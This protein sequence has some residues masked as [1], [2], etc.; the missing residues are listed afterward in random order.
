M[1]KFAVLA[2]GAVIVANASAQLWDNG[3]ISTG[4][5]H[6]TGVNAPGGG[7]W[8]E[9][10]PT[11][12]TLGFGLNNASNIRV[13]DDF[14]VGGGGWHV[15]S[16]QFY[17]YLTGAVNPTATAAT[18]AIWNGRPGDAGSSIILGDQATNVMS[19]VVMSNI[20]RT[21]RTT[22]DTT[23]RQ[24]LVTINLNW[25]LAPG[26]YWAEW[27]AT[28]VSFSPPVTLVGQL[29]KPGANGRQWNAGTWVDLTDL[30]S[31]APQDM[32]FIINGNPV[33]E[34]ATMIAL[35]LGVAAM[36]RRRRK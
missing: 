25:N 23:R 26:T 18:L 15:T 9:L 3:P 17:A 16:F 21:G 1:R 8:S 6:S 14:T 13:A 33:P 7:V 30:G 29:G 4:P 11:N 12:S 10:Q 34:P 35:G 19:S 31:S 5:V 28:G 2:L 27:G 20:Y 32:N 36:A 24:Q 22:A